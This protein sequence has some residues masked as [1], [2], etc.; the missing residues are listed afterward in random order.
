MKKQIMTRCLVVLCGIM[1]L[2]SCSFTSVRAVEVEKSGMM[3][4]DVVFVIDASGSMNTADPQKVTIDAFDLFMSLCDETC[5]VGYVVYTE[6]IVDSQPIVRLDSEGSVESLRQK[7]SDI[8]YDQHGDTDISLGVTKAMNFL[9]DSTR[10]DDGRK[11]AIILLSDGNTHLLRT[12]PRTEEES[13]AEMKKTLQT[14]REKEIPIYAIGL[15]YDG[16]MGTDELKGIADGSG[17]VINGADGTVPVKKFFEINTADKITGIMRSIINNYVDI[18]PMNLANLDFRVDNK[19][20]YA[21][22]I[23]ID[24]KIPQKELNPRLTVRL[25]SSDTINIPLDSENVV[26]T[27]TK[28]YTLIKIFSPVVGVWNLKLDKVTNDNCQVSLATVYTVYL[29]QSVNVPSVAGETVKVTASL[30]N[31]SGVIQ[32]TDFLNTITMKATITGAM[33]KEVTLKGDG[34]GIFTGEFLASS[35][36][37]YYVTTSAVSTDKKLS[38]TSEE[39]V[40]SVSDASDKL[41]LQEKLSSD[42]I[43]M[44][45]PVTISVRTVNI[46]TDTEIAVQDT[47]FSAV[48]RGEN[49]FEETVPLRQVTDSQYEGE[50]SLQEKGRYTVTAVAVSNSTGDKKESND[51]ILDV[52]RREMELVNTQPVYLKVSAGLNSSTAEVQ[53]KDY[54]YSDAEDTLT[55]RYEPAGSDYYSIEESQNAGTKALTIKGIK[56]GEGQTKVIVTNQYGETQTIVLN[57]IVEDGT[58]LFI[59]LS[60]I[61]AVIIGLG[62][63]AYFLLRPKMSGQVQIRLILPD[64]LRRYQPRQLTFRL[65]SRHKVSLKKLYE[66]NRN[67]DD[68]HLKAIT[69]AGIA[70]EAEKITLTASSG[71]SVKI[72]YKHINRINN[73]DASV[74]SVSIHI[75]KV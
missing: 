34:A 27:S 16:L 36:G 41:M 24:T 53:L 66:L 50:I 29:K 7:M 11:K 45:K 18:T 26:V 19:N 44:G 55:I 30:N 2:F 75:F 46:D 28:S 20:I 56:S 33:E 3:N 57:V 21:I 22:Y 74:N 10:P 25:N 1:L 68:T 23:V 70:R 4:L 61:G 72:R 31:G 65:P 6:K 14:L 71:R 43:G 62:I 13:K 8:T 69:Q 51:C 58:I 64:S 63:G 40:F 47:V 15:N 39:Y 67:Y 54:I 42:K 49:Q 52:V 32:D 17:T 60:I 38:K 12:A 59:I 35:S 48:V 5:G 9:T 73:F 37:T